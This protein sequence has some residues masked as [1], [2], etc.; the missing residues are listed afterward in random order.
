M[1]TPRALY[2][3]AN[4][5]TIG[6]QAGVITRRKNCR[7]SSK[8]SVVGV[9]RSMGILE[10]WVRRPVV[11]THWS[12]AT[13]VFSSGRWLFLCLVIIHSCAGCLEL[14]GLHLDQIGGP[15]FSRPI[16]SHDPRTKDR[17]LVPLSHRGREALCTSTKCCSLPLPQQ[18]LT[19]CAIITQ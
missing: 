17:G 2:L 13:R 9:Q 5:F 14:L 11:V 1:S 8:G 19:F 15:S 12:A 4:I 18:L 6:G 3:K 7:T 10:L 16:L